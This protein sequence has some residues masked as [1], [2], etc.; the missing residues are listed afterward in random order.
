MAGRRKGSPAVG[1]PCLNAC[2]THAE[3]CWVQRPSLSKRERRWGKTPGE[4]RREGSEHGNG[5]TYPIPALRHGEEPGGRGC[6]GGVGQAGGP[7]VGHSDA[8][9]G[10]RLSSALA[11]PLAPIYSGAPALR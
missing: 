11:Q 7:G 4:G 1:P 3:P 2:L 6:S 10:A 8:A 5:G 9:A